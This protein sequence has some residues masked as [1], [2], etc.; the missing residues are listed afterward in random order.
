[1]RAK[2]CMFLAMGVV[3]IFTI[4]A[5]AKEDAAEIRCF[6]QSFQVNLRENLSGQ[7]DQAIN[8]TCDVNKP[9]SSQLLKLSPGGDYP[10]TALICCHKK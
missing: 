3:W 5:S 7:L 9:F 10:W 4:F 8:K 6:Q 1:M 2:G